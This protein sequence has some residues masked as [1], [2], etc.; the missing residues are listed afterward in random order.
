MSSIVHCDAI[1]VMEKGSVVE[2]GTH[3]ELIKSS[4]VYAKMWQAQNGEALEQ[5]RGAATAETVKG[6]SGEVET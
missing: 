2:T 5:G 6:E 4:G 1:I 3:Q